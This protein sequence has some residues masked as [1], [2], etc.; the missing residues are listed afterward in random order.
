MQME[1]VITSVSSSAWL[2]NPKEL[3]KI[4][5]RFNIESD[6]PCGIG[7]NGKNGMFFQPIFG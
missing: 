2:D 3:F 7:L 4:S 6:S 5:S 1:K